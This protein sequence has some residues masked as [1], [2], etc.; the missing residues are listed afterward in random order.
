[1]R[2]L[3]VFRIERNEPLALAQVA[4]GQQDGLVV[5]SNLGLEAQSSSQYGRTDSTPLSIPM[6]CFND[7]CCCY[8]CLCRSS[9][10]VFGRQDRYCAPSTTA[11]HILRGTSAYMVDTLLYRP[12]SCRRCKWC[13]PPC[14][15]FRASLYPR[16]SEPN[17]GGPP[18]WPEERHSTGDLPL[19][20][21]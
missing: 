14:R 15:R 1:M 16:A 19:S 8:R 12:L 13:T 2:L 20:G 5:Q 10:P 6:S 4:L 17:S 11:P 21:C 7:C 9:R 3:P 18:L